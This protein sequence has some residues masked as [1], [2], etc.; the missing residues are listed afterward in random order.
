MAGFVTGPGQH[1]TTAMKICLNDILF[2]LSFALDAVEH[3]LLGVSTNHGKR[4]ALLATMV[5]SRMGLSGDELT[6]LACCAI[7]HDNALTEYIQARELASLNNSAEDPELDR[8][9]C[10]LGENNITLLPWRCNITNVILYHHE[11]ADGSGPFGKNWQ[12]TPIMAQLVRLGD[13]IDARFNLDH[14]D[15]YKYQLVT[16]FLKSMSGQIFTREMGE[17][18]SEVL[19]EDFL[20]SLNSGSLDQLISKTVPSRTEDLGLEEVRKIALL[21]ARITDYKSTFTSTHSLG[22]A[23]KSELMARH[24]G[25]DDEKT[26]RFFFAG[27]LHDIGK[28]IVSNDILEKPARLTN[29]EF[30]MMQNHAFY[31]YVILR[32]INGMSDI[33]AWASHHHEKLDGT[34]YPFGMKGSQLS[35]E[36]RLLTCIDVYQALREDRPYKQGFTHQKSIEIMSSMAK[37]GQIDSGIVDDMNEVF[38]ND[39]GGSDS[40]RDPRNPETFRGAGSERSE[41]HPFRVKES[42]VEH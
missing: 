9:H 38:R 16:D 5:G 6:D 32:K 41:D 12:E 19:T 1:Q 37:D 14:V 23:Q 34:G 31:T 2:A 11:N 40:A 29:E 24:Y 22:V 36:E 33:T 39:T 20:K 7:L 13:V 8:A 25:W 27:A 35:H 4:A 18:A 42:T 3:E 21:F 10:T 15:S 30:A 28:L 26:T 17:A